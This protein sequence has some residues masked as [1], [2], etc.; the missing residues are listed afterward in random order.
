MI[1]DNHDGESVPG[2]SKVFDKCPGC[3]STERFFEG[4]I[5]KL[6]DKGLLGTEVQYFDFQLQ[7]GIAVSSQK[8]ALLP[9]GTE[10][11]SFTRA[12]DNCADCGLVYCVRLEQ[13][14]VRKSI[15]LAPQQPVMLNR[16]DRRRMEQLRGDLRPNNPHLS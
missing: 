5:N 6:H 12:I 16:A 8:A 13:G 4:L 7:Q 2:F 15:N 14:M 11:P 9:I 3:G 1:G 10:I